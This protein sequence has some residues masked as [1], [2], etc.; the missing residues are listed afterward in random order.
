MTRTSESAFRITGQDLA[1]YVGV[2]PIQFVIFRDETEEVAEI[3][4]I[5]VQAKVAEAEG[6]ARRR[7]AG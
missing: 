5:R 2:P 7:F 6:G 1:R 4:G 3:D